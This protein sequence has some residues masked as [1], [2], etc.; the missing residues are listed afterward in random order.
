MWFSTPIAT[1]TYEVPSTLLALKHPLLLFAMLIV[2]FVGLLASPRRYRWLVLFWLAVPPVALCLVRV[3]FYH[4]YLSY[5]LPLIAIVM[6]RGIDY[7]AATIQPRR[8]GRTVATACLTLLVALPSLAQLPNYY[9]HL[10]KLPWRELVS[11]VEANHEPGDVVFVNVRADLWSIRTP[12]DWYGTVPA[13]E[14]RWE[15]FLEDG[16][17]ADPEQLL[18]LP[19]VARDHP[20]VWLVFSTIDKET[21]QAIVDVLQDRFRLVQMQEFAYSEVMLFEALSS[22]ATP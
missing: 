9:N 12:P 14:L 16:T 10:Q 15:A 2:F 22:E 13:D 7:L 6:A 17:L 1:W 11:F 4:R 18:M 19:A 5:F 21:E 8:P 3:R 20:R